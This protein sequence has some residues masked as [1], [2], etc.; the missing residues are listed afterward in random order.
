MAFMTSP[1]TVEADGRHFHFFREHFPF[2][3]FPGY[4]HVDG[5]SRS[6]R[7]W[8]NGRA[9]TPNELADYLEAQYIQQS[10][11]GIRQAM[12]KYAELRSL[13]S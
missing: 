2:G 6:F 10:E 4:M 11:M 5:E 3:D 12:S 13:A 8:A 1:D 7:F 9:M